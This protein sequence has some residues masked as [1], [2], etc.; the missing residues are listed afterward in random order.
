MKAMHIGVRLGV[1]V[2]AEGT[3]QDELVCNTTL[4]STVTT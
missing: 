4:Y 3:T 1:G 2:K